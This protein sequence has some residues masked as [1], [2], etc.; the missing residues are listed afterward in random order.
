MIEILSVD[1]STTGL[2]GLMDANKMQD[3]NTITAGNDG[4]VLTLSGLEIGRRLKKR[5]LSPVEVLDVHI[6]KIEEVNKKINALVVK[7]YEKARQEAKEAEKNLMRQDIKTLSPLYG[8]P[9]TIK[10][11]YAVKGLSWVG[12][13]VY[14]KDVVADAD[15]DIVKAYRKQGLIIMGKTNVPEASLWIET[16]NKV[17]GR[18]NNPHNLKCTPGGSSGG[19]AALIGSGASPIGLGSDVAGSIRMPCVFSGIVGHKP[20]GGLIQER[21]HWPSANGKLADFNTFGPLARR[22]EDIIHL[23]KIIPK[24]RNIN[25]PDSVNLRELTYYYYDDAGSPQTDRSVKK[26]I[27]DT[28]QA[29]LDDGFK[30]Q[31]YKPTG[32][33]WHFLIW[34]M[35]MKEFNQQ[36]VRDILGSGKRVSLMKQS[37]KMTLGVSDITFPALGLGV[38]SILKMGDRHIKKFV[39]KC[40]MMKEEISQRLGDRGVLICPAYPTVA[41]RHRTPLVNPFGFGYCG[42]FNVTEFPSTAVPVG[43]S[44]SGLP[45]GVQIV[46]NHY[47]DHISL[48]VGLHLEK[49]FGGWKIPRI[50]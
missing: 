49:V 36:D 7:N 31:P 37:L 40:Y 15:A 29:L 41:P 26:A 47:H 39:N 23:M 27:S 50:V 38:M 17:Y 46:S 18:T 45:V 12:G 9:C 48:A 42:I 34:I 22:M 13:S 11:A 44:D 20:T 24:T 10:D 28:V 8:V 19:E 16:C 43:F 1:Q 33:K 14:R 6:N 25:D 21:L 2:E 35:M 32:M 3:G 5:E 4:E 30:V